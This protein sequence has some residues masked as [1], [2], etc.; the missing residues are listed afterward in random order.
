[1]LRNLMECGLIKTCIVVTHRPA[2]KE[3]CSRCYQICDGA[4][5]EV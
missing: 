1:M 3:L 4:V 2:G 5:Q